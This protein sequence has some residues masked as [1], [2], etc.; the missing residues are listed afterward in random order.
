MMLGFYTADATLPYMTIRVELSFWSA[1]WLQHGA[2]DIETSQ[3]ATDA[4][5]RG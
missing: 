1:A 3:I 2:S 4:D 5:L